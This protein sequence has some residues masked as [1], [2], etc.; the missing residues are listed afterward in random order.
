MRK[1]I[2]GLM[3]GTLALGL[4]AGCSGPSGSTRREIDEVRRERDQEISEME[5]DS[6]APE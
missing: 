6:R 3:V 2:L 5:A 1:L 4:F